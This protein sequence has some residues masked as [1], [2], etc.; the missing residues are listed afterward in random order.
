MKVHTNYIGITPF[1]HKFK[2]TFDGNK[3][4]DRVTG[5]SPLPRVNKLRKIFLDATFT[6]D[7]K[8]GVLATEAYKKYEHYPIVQ[9]RGLVLKYLLENLPLFTYDD[10][11]II[12]THGAAT[13]HAHIYPE[14]SIE[15]IMDEMENFPFEKREFDN[16]EITEE[17]KNKLKPLNEY[18][19]GR[20]LAE[21]IENQLTF[22]EKKGSNHGIGIFLLNLYQFGGVGHLTFDYEKLLKVGFGGLIEQATK[23]L[24]EVDPTSPECYNERS[25]LVGFIEALEGAVT[26]VTR[27]KEE[28]IKLAEEETDATRK[29]ELNEIVK[30]LEQIARGPATNFWNASQLVHFATMITL[31]E[32]NGHAVSYG[33]MDKYLR[34]YYEK[35]LNSGEFTKE[36][37]QE[38]IECHIIKM[39]SPCK[40]RDKMTAMANTGRG[41]AG[42]SLTL[43]G[44]DK[45]GN[46]VTNDLTF[47]YLDASAHTRLVG[48]WP[49]V[50]MHD[51][52]PHELKVKIANMMKAGFGHPKVFNDKVTI[53]S[54]LKLG[55]SLEDAREYVVIGCVEPSIPG[56][57]FGWH[58]AAYMNIAKPM[59]LAFNN[60][61]CILCGEHCPR[62]SICAGVGKKVGLETGSLETFKNIEEV[63]DA[64]KKQIEHFVM[65]MVTGINIMENVHKEMGATPFVSSLYDNCIVTAKDLSAG[66]A[67][68]NHTC[69]QAA[70]IA[71]ASD[72]LA[73]V[74]QLLFKENSFNFTGK[75]L[76]NALKANWE[77]YDKLYSL[78]NSSKLKHYGNDDDYADEF[79]KFVFDLYCDTVSPYKNTR[80]GTYKPGVYG[81]SANV[82]FGMISGPSIDGRKAGEPISDN[83]GPV[84]TAAGAHD[85][86]G[87]TAIANSASKLDHAKASNG[88]L[89]NWKFSPT[90]VSGEAGTENLINLID[91]FFGKGGMHSQFN[92]ISTDTMKAA[93]ANPEQ[94]KDMLVRV[95]GYCAYFVE[96]SEPLQLDLIAR[97]ELSFE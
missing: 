35:S 62:Y 88:T 46:D 31:I 45:D 22:E 83:L 65:H 76:L 41:F 52:T 42:E 51:E 89:L 3:T 57:E 60:G 4:V 54:Q 64:Y 92:I 37:M 77:G 91:I 82:F 49:C 28:Y 7:A 10:E 33:R 6:I 90:N 94:Y 18:W 38:I 95:A 79:A 14:F 40:L 66:G 75:D 97:T 48:P 70:S 32:S 25:T 68:I 53:E 11:L 15:W 72:S 47:M 85:I 67:E 44:I 27:Y 17:T 29:E 30:N 59:E 26:Y 84:H 78:V 34:P 19:K 63:K 1:D 58:D 96:L 16:Y 71:T 23:R 12:G 21:K 8:R 93:K 74:D 36:F 87:P 2:S 43:G 24:E 61:N 20:T 5:F 39:L 81:V 80:G 55:R 73:V 9:K 50:R 13:K 69:P 56:K 86:S